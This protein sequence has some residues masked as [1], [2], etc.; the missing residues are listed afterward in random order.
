MSGNMFFNSWSVPPQGEDV[1][2]PEEYSY[3]VTGEVSSPYLRIYDH[4]LNALPAPAVPPNA[5]ITLLRMNK[6]RTLLVVGQSAAPYIRIYNMAD[7]SLAGTLSHLP[8]AALETAVFVNDDAHLM[9]GQAGSNVISVYNTSNWQRISGGPA[10]LPGSVRTS[11]CISDTEVV[12]T[13][14]GAPFVR[15][16]NTA[17]WASLTAPTG[18]GYRTFCVDKTEDD[19]TVALGLV[20]GM[21]RLYGVGTDWTWQKNVSNVWSLATSRGVKFVRNG[22]YLIFANEAAAYPFAVVRI[23]DGVVELPDVLPS[24]GCWGL[25]VSPDGSV[26]AVGSRGVQKLLLYDAQTLMLLGGPAAAPVSHCNAVLFT[27]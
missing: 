16:I 15:R 20:T 19:S 8:T 14:D 3:L 10:N 9:I 17:N 13:H 6:A 4:A 23:S 22:Q 24:A 26:I 5:A 12:F 18:V 25:D 7:Y 21:A 1:P 2:S 11:L 27:G